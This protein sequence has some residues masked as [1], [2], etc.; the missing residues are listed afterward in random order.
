MV[1][2]FDSSGSVGEFNFTVEKEFA[3]N[4]TTVFNIGPSGTQVGAVAFSGAT[5]FILPLDKHSTSLTVSDGIMDIPYN[6]FPK[7]KFN[8]NTSGALRSVREEVFTIEGG[9]RPRS[10]AFPRVV[11]VI[12]DGRSNID[13]E[14]TIPSAEALHND[15]V[16]V[17]AIGIGERKINLD[18]LNGIASKPEYASLIG[19][20]DLT[21]LQG[22][23]ATFSDSACRGKC[24]HYVLHIELQRN[25]SN[26]VTLRTIKSGCIKQVVS[27]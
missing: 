17:F 16:S 22:V 5:Y 11:I 21:Q 26:A 3:V 27:T 1:F 13:R 20:F 24:C 12:T 4:I 15:S 8:T 7:G 19:G 18:E 10:A 14:L 23:E 9:A 25:L 6:E 2:V